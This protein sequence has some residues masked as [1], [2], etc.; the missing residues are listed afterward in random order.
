MNP[1]LNEYQNLLISSSSNKAD[2]SVLLAACEEY[3]LTRATAERIVAEVTAAVRDWRT[4]A[5]RIGIA[6]REQDMFAGRFIC[7]L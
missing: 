5:Q 4:V 2:L 1:A 3:M 6:K 7:E